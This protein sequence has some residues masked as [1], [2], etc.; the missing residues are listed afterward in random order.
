MRLGLPAIV[1]ALAALH[2]A[3]GCHSPPRPV[4]RVKDEGRFPHAAAAHLQQPC[5]ACHAVTAVLEGKLQRPGANDHAPCD[6][7][8]CHAE[9][10]LRP[11]GKLCTLCHVSVIASRPGASVAAFY[12][13]RRGAR[14]LASR[15]NHTLHL[16]R[17]RMDD[18]VGFHIACA[19]CH[20]PAKDGGARDMQLPSH[21]DC[22]PC[23]TGKA[24][25][26]MATC[27]GCHKVRPDDP[28]RVRRM[29]AGDLRFHHGLHDVD[30]RGKAIACVT[31]H[32]STMRSAASPS[33]ERPPTAACVAC[34]DD[35]VR[36]P[37]TAVMSH[38][39]TCHASQIAGFAQIGAPRSHISRRDRPEDHT[40]AFRRDHGRDATGDAERCATC[41]GE[42]NGSRSDNCDQCHQS[43]KPQDHVITWREYEHGH[44]AAVSAARCGVCHGGEFCI[45]CH[46]LPPRSHA[47]PSFRMGN[48]AQAARNNL[49]SCFACHLTQNECGGCHMGGFRR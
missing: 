23:H 21:T 12:P 43:M 37:A 46:S 16:D 19:D 8:K 1:A 24:K 44:E 3:Q 34:H 7:N 15:F 31:C 2:G 49:R 41:H 5:T 28:Q 29:I 33:D 6:D 32:E 14:A 45:S 17:R 26:A 38:C 27:D 30:R 42:M 47:R 10:F 35:P 11:P 48:H 18:A 20:V 13:P 40:L 4:E 25:P 22:V 9:S 39:E 36:T